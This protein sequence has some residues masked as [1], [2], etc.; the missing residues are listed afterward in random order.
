MYNTKWLILSTAVGSFLHMLRHAQH[1]KSAQDPLLTH[2]N[3]FRRNPMRT[4]CL[5]FAVLCLAGCGYPSL[6]RDELNHYTDRK[7]KR[8][9]EIIKTL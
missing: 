4:F 1:D 3:L 2:S 9:A 7:E 5:L 8:V 6:T